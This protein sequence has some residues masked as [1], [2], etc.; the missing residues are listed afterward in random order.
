M[1]A[2]ARQA[3]ATPR[4][5]H[6]STPRRRTDGDPGRPAEFERELIKARIGEGGAR[7]SRGNSQG[8]AALRPHQR[9]DAI[10]SAQRR[11]GVDNARPSVT[12]YQQRRSGGPGRLGR[13][14]LKSTCLAG[15]V[16]FRAS[17]SSGSVALSYRLFSLYVRSVK[18]ILQILDFSAIPITHR[19]IHQSRWIIV[20][21][22]ESRGMPLCIWPE[23]SVEL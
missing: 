12:Q 2:V 21:T 5:T 4:P 11:R 23:S 3:A 14:M 9:R 7:A 20:R 6:G 19:S 15:F 10:C 22:K 8:R 17:R 13:D 16:G 1:Q 18:N